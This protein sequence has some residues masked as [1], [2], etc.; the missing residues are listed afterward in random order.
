MKNLSAFLGLLLSLFGRYPELCRGRAFRCKSSLHFVALRFAPGFPLQSL[1]QNYNANKL[2][3][4]TICFLLFITILPQTSQAQDV[5]FTQFFTT[6][7]ALNP[8]Q[9]G[10]YDGNYRVGFNFKAQ[11]PWAIGSKVYNYH[12]ESPYVDLSFGEKKIKTGWMG[13]GLN[14]L[15]DEAGDGLLT[16]RRLGLSYAYHQAFDKEHRYVLSAGVALNYIIR[17]VDFSKFYFNNQWI[18]DAGFSTSVASNEPLKRE[19]FGMV[20]LGAGINLGA[21]VHNQLKLD[22]GFS[23]LHLNRPKHS[24]FNNGERVGFRYQA[25]I[26]SVISFN[27]NVSLT[28]NIYY[29][30]QKKASEIMLGAMVGYGLN[31]R[32]SS[33]PNNLLYFGVF[34]RIKDAISPLVGYQYKKTRL[35]LN[36]DITLSKLANVARANGGPEFS[37]VHIGSW[38]KQF[39]GKKVYCPRF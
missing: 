14:F 27:Q 17:S 31:S 22:F 19:S 13:V 32:K 21:Q 2:R 25:S 8:A 35:L 9:T 38:G 36:Y 18:E 3:F 37:I 34:Y 7:L 12:T 28:A 15:N 33:A 30:N 23:M 1:T 5:H 26:S 4:F 20:D 29:G 24:F 6:P 11:W 39:G 16:Y 10:Y